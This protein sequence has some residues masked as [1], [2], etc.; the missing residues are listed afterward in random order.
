RG[1]EFPTGLTFFPPPVPS[2]QQRAWKLGALHFSSPVIVG[3]PPHPAWRDAGG[4]GLST[5]FTAFDT[6]FNGNKTRKTLAIVGAQDGM[7]HGFNA[8]SFRLGN[9]P[10]CAVNLLRGCYATISGGPDY[11]DGTEVFSY[12]PPLLLSQLKNNHPSV[13]SYNPA[14]NPPAEVD[15]S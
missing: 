1:W 12:V 11:G 15:G 14:S 10:Q 13:R 7:V 8:G 9:D 2:T 3:P 4:T 6:F 5:Y